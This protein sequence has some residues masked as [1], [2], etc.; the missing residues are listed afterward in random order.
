MDK[1]DVVSPLGIEV[2]K[3]KGVSPRLADLNGKTVAEVW[4]GVFKGDQ[5][6]PVIR[7]L[8]KQKF[9]SINIIPFTDTQTE[10]IMNPNDVLPGDPRYKQNYVSLMNYAYQF[11]P[12][13]PGY[14]T[15][16]QVFNDFADKYK[17]DSSGASP[18]EFALRQIGQAAVGETV[19]KAQPAMKMAIVL[20]VVTAITNSTPMFRLAA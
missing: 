11:V 13:V 20:T 9:P 15:G 17:N 16:N 14:S 1:Y 3:R 7:K 19:D 5:T 18:S 10:D 4:N 6:F 8:L 12:Q 2:I